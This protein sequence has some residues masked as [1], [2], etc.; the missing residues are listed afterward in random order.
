MTTTP[1]PGLV[2]RRNSGKPQG[3]GCVHFHG[4]RRGALSLF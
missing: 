1:K 3:H 4:Q 2:D